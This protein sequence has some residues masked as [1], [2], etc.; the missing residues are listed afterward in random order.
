M[1]RALPPE[2][3]FVYNQLPK[4]IIMQNNIFL[5]YGEDTYSSNKK[6]N[7]WRDQFIKKYGD[8]SNIEVIEGKKINIPQFETN[9]SS[10]PFLCEK[11]LIIVKKFL[12]TAKK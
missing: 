12:S 2:G 3:L 9:I 8:E 4:Q 11:I 5:F 10:M 6:V 7:L 1:K